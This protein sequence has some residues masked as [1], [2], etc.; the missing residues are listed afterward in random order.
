MQANLG[1][2]DCRSIRQTMLNNYLFYKRI[3]VTQRTHLL[4]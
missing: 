4:V 3:E 2:F 1:M